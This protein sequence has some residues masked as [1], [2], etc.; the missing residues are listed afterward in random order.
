ME[1]WGGEEGRATMKV[2]N[3]CLLSLLRN[4]LFVRCF[5]FPP[6]NELNLFDY[7]K[8][9]LE[10]KNRDNGNERKRIF[11]LWISDWMMLLLFHILSTLLP[12]LHSFTV[13][14]QERTVTS[15]LFILRIGRR[16]DRGSHAAVRVTYS[17][18]ADLLNV[19]VRMTGT[20][21]SSL[22]FK[23]YTHVILLQW[24]RS[25]AFL[26]WLFRPDSPFQLTSFR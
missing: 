1:R 21:Q 19:W 8:C 13:D 16:P 6:A 23:Y 11:H 26:S 5:F 4:T 14:W 18:S 2:I 25:T 9:H 7:P 15:S 3:S 17:V 22:H 12:R 20:H 10:R 24:L